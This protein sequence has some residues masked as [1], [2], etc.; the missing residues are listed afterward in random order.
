M[1]L[2]IALAA[3]TALLLGACN[4]WPTTMPYTQAMTHPEK[5]PT[6]SATATRPV[7]FY[8]GHHRYMVLPAEVNLGAARTAPVSTGANVS[9]FS[10]QGDEAPYGSLFARGPNGR[11]V[12]VG[13]I[14]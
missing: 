2:K 5:Y 4:G 11:T 14:D 12:A 1:N 9:V 13:V 7:E 6:Y 3:G 10:L 8:A